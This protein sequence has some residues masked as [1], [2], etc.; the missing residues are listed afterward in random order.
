MMDGVIEAKEISKGLMGEMPSLE[1]APD[2]FDIIEFGGVFGQPL[3][4]EPMGSF[5]ECG[6]CRLA[7]MD[8]AVVE[9]DDDRLGGPAG[10]GAVKTVELLQMGDEVAAALAPRGGD[11]ELAASP[12]EAAH[13]GDLLGLPGGRHAQVGATSCPSAGEIRMRQRLALVAEQQHD[14]AG[15]R[16]LP[17]LQRV[18]RPAEAEP[19]FWRSTL[20]SC[21][22]DIA[23]PSRLAISSAR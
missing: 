9:H 13:Y 7:D 19:P 15:L 11:D 22:R 10:P 14:V 23:T 2:D 17:S 4:G 3:D 20:E 6:A 21:E 1:V 18:P 16:V 12:I 5:G 8:R